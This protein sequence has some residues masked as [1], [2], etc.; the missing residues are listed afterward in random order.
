MEALAP[1]GD[2]RDVEW[3]KLRSAF[4]MWDD[5]LQ[6]AKADGP[7]LLGR[8]QGFADFVIAS[9]LLWMSLMWGEGSREWED[10]KTWSGGRWVTYLDGMRKYRTVV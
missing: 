5:S 2:A 6:K 1:T 7:Y 9:F 10:I 3:G 4:E 8:E